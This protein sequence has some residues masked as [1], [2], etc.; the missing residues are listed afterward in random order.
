MKKQ[1]GFTLIEVMIAMTLLAFL[2]IALYQATARS[3]VINGRL[4]QES[5][6]YT[7]VILSLQSVQTD[8]AAVYSPVLDPD[9]PA[10]PADTQKLQ[11]F[12]SA[13]VRGDG[14]R[15]ARLK[16]SREKLT[17]INNN[18]RR[19][20]ADSPVSDFQ[21]V[22]WEISRGEN[23]AY[24]LLRAN[25]W[26][27]FRYEE[28]SGKKPVRVALLDNLMSAS[29]SYYRRENKT[30]ED[31]WD[32]ESPYAKAENRFPDLIKLKVDVPDPLNA[33]NPQTWEIIVKP[34]L[35]LNGELAPTDSEV[36]SQ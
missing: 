27:A 34:H 2:G 24:S 31:T 25:D 30:W 8:L 32:S 6:D 9:Q 14:I 35:S 11:E 29:F 23:N 19:V 22:S 36:M 17:F 15:R 12:W 16:G 3:Y 7:S 20:D 10:L 26:D 28:S 1:A 5:A 4:S 21:K 33:A 13:P 18:N